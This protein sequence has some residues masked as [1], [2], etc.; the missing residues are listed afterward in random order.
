M[1]GMPL[2]I[3]A[4]DPDPVEQLRRCI[5]EARDAGHPMADA[6]ALATAAGDGTPSVRM[7]LLR[8]LDAAGLRFFTNRESRKGTDVSANPRA[9]ATFWWPQTDRQV[10]VAGAVTPLGDTESQAYWETRPRAS[11]L[12]AMASQQGREIGSRAELE[13]RV[14]ELEA[15][16][17]DAVPLPRF[18][19]GYLL[20]PELFE[21]WESRP[22]RL[23]DRIEYLPDRTGG[24]RR[25]RLQP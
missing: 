10:R 5:A 16:Y 22:H 25:R 4:L 12:S 18:W 1:A 3:D 24:W 20:R 23:H 19:G 11:R 9:A 21:F 15:R 8:G 6:F 13:T 17:P 7:V 2:E 14:Q